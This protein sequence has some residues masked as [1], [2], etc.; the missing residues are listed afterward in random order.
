MNILK[1]GPLILNSFPCPPDE[2]FGATLAPLMTECVDA[3]S[4]VLNALLFTYGFILI[5][6][7][8]NYIFNNKVKVIL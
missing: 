6:K 5:K 1:G 4:D 8:L 3:V 2:N 7:I